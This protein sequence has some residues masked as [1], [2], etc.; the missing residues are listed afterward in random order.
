MLCITAV[1]GEFG[2]LR[3][4]YISYDMSVIPHGLTQLSIKKIHE[5]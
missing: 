1:L 4:A 5:I 3:E 2:K